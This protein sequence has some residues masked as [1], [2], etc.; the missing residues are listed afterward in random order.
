MGQKIKNEFTKCHNRG[1][2]TG[3]NGRPDWQYLSK[4]SGITVEVNYVISVVEKNI[5]EKVG[6]GTDISAVVEWWHL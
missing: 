5:R 6:G 1:S 2:Y 4:L 3:G